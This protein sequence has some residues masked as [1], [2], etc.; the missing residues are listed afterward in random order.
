MSLSYREIEKSRIKD[1]LEFF[2]N[3]LIPK[4]YPGVNH[5]VVSEQYHEYQG[6]PYFMYG[7]HIN[8][9]FEFDVELKENTDLKNRLFIYVE[10][11]AKIGIEQFRSGNVSRYVENVDFFYD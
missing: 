1:D 5:I 6:Y 8:P 2:L 9:H 4:K 3:R 11:V 10:E 7:I